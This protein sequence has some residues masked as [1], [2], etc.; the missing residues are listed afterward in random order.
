MVTS[1]HPSFFAF[2][3]FPVSCKYGR[4]L[5]QEAALHFPLHFS[6][7]MHF[8]VHSVTKPPVLCL[9]QQPEVLDQLAGIRELWMDGNR[10][11]FLP[12]VQI[13]VTPEHI[14]S[15]NYPPKHFLDKQFTIST[16]FLLLPLHYFPFSVHLFSNFFPHLHVPCFLI[17]GSYFK[18]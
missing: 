4:L 18:Y 3:P 7:F 5:F 15:W 2:F 13:A 8:T 11:T 14:S 17:T 16:Y 9:Y 12:G 10:L 1:S 6:L